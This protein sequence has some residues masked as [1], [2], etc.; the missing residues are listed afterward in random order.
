MA[1]V[2]RVCA[3]IFRTGAR[4][5]CVAETRR[6]DVGLGSGWPGGDGTLRRTHRGERPGLVETWRDGDLTETKVDI[7]E[8][9][10]EMSEEGG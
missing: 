7:D 9:G 3:N 1:D 2:E 5:T 8:A 6:L 4:N 10:I